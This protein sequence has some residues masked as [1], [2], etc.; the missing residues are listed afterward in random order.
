ME[1]LHL[2]LGGL[3]VVSTLFNILQALKVG[4]YQGRIT[5]LS[6]QVSNL[7]RLQK[8]NDAYRRRHLQLI[9]FLQELHSSMALAKY[10]AMHQAKESGSAVT[11]PGGTAGAWHG[12]VQGG[13]LWS[14]LHDGHPRPLTREKLCE[15]DMEPYKFLVP[16]QDGLRWM[17]DA[18]RRNAC[19]FSFDIS[20]TQSHND[21]LVWD[22]EE[23]LQ[24]V[25]GYV[26]GQDFLKEGLSA[27]ALW[28][29]HADSTGGHES[30]RAMLAPHVK[31]ILWVYR[32]L[33]DGHTFRALEHLSD[34]KEILKQILLDLSPSPA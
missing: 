14:L 25:K 23:T 6:S 28:Q 27:V 4:R 11:I 12:K 34:P 21:Y 17:L 10:K 18:L 24:G 32:Q 30:A 13:F 22:L 7:N 26:Q 33:Q 8:A 31:G 3:L 5:E 2:I 1:N 20:P 15:P 19:P 29:L 9:S 16:F